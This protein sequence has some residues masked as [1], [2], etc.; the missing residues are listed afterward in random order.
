[1]IFYV[2]SRKIQSMIIPSSFVATSAAK[3]FVK[4]VSYYVTINLQTSNEGNLSPIT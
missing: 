1:M 3:N 4:A 2:I